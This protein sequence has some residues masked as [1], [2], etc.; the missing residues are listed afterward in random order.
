[1]GRYSDRGLMQV[2][3]SFCGHLAEWEWRMGDG[4]RVA[5]AP[6]VGFVNASLPPAEFSVGEPITTRSWVVRPLSTPVKA[7]ECACEDCAASAHKNPDRECE[8]APRKRKPLVS[9]ASCPE[10]P[11]HKQ[12]PNWPINSVAW[13][14]RSILDVA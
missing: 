8:S 2:Q 5:G 12:L 3:L 14:A 9:A 11:W 1:M 13:G 10:E 6:P 7:Y 4:T